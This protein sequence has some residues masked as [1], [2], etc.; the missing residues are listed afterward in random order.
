MAITFFIAPASSTPSTSSLRVQAEIRCGKFLLQLGGER[1]IAATRR[2]TAVGSPRAASS[3]NDGPESTAIRGASEAGITS[4]ITSLMRL[5][6]AGSSPFV[7]LT[8]IARAEMS[9]RRRRVDRARV[10]R[11]HR[12][13]NDCRAAQALRRSR[14]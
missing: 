14:A 3:A 12:A 4:A 13:H 10:S 1:R 5:C 2:T 9:I 7:A 6:V 8:T 11:W